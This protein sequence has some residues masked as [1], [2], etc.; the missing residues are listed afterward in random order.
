MTRPGQVIDVRGRPVHVV[1]DGSGRPPLLLTAGLGGAWY[2]W[3]PLMPHLPAAH[4]IVRVDRPG[5]GGSPGHGRVPT[6]R[7]ESELLAAVI[8][9]CCEQGAIVVAHSLA[10]LHAEALARSR[11]DLVRG[12]VLV[13]VSNGPSGV[14]P[15]GTTTPRQVPIRGT[16]TEPGTA[17]AR[18]AWGLAELADRTGVSA[19]IG[20]QAFAAALRLLTHGPPPDAVLTAGRRTF[21][22]AEPAA[23]AWC[24]LIAYRRTVLDLAAL[25]RTDFPSIPAHVLTATGDLGRRSG[26]RWI[27]RQQA[28][29]VELGARHRVVAEA[30]HFLAWHRPDAVAAA[31]DDVVG[32][33]R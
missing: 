20:P 2:D 1:A 6:L 14:R 31:V 15:T 16:P 4:R 24:E 25:R 5:L 27:E 29:A 32:R 3:S 26:L 11:P 10:G 12:L 22:S 8:E 21:R 23:A 9:D 28:L 18:A 7:R 33:L 17:A 30:G 19:R 13:D